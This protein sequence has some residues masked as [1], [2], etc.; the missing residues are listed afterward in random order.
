MK[1]NTNGNLYTFLYAAVMVIVVAL[2]L[3]FVALTLK[4][5]QEKNAR[6]EKMQNILQTI[7]PAD[8][9]TPEN[10]EDLYGKYIIE[11]YAV[12]SKGEITIEGKD[13]KEKDRVF[14]INLKSEIAKPV[15]ERTLPVY[16]AK[17]DDGGSKVIFPLRGKG[18][19][20]PIWGYISLDE[21]YNTIF[22]AVFDHKG[23]TPGLGAEINKESFESQ[24]K[25]K[26]IFEDGKLVSVSVY[27]G[28]NGAAEL[29][30]DTEH[31]V[32]GISGGTI[33]SKGLEAMMKTDW[34][35][36]YGEY[37]QSKFDSNK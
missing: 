29:A 23:E 5:K 6:T 12:N 24:F 16:K 33:T 31:G 18:L 34:L 4:P 30:G 17:L 28:G 14:N 22:G 35:F 27:K 1:I 25:G 3:T 2:G 13:Q 26:K 20:G 7:L 21:D 36:A 11:Q 15:E 8:Q 37:L 9:I 32:D 19:W 10:A